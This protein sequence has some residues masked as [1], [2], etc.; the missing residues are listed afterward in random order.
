E[1]GVVA[2]FTSK[3]LSG[4]QP[5]IN[6]NGKQ[7]RDY[8]YVEDVV[9]ANLSALSYND[10]GI[11][12]IG[13]GIETDVNQLFNMLNEFSRSKSLEIHGPPKKGEQQRSVLDYSMAKNTL[14]WR[15]SIG[16]SDGLRKTVEYFKNHQ[17]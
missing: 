11:F 2:I 12:N 10:S 7:T 9:R 13:T 3:M 15:P 8:V 16:L 1:A 6:G 17:K 14:N 5:V 4:D